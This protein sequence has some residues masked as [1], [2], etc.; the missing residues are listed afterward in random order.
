[1]AQIFPFRAY[2]YS[3]ERVDLS[4]VLTQP[5]DKITPAMQARYYGL[6]PHNLVRIERGRGEEGDTLTNNVYTRAAQTLEEWIA[7]GTLLRE[8]APAIY[9]YFQEYTVSG[10]RTRHV[11]KGF[12]ALGRIED[13]SAGVVYRH[14]L[15]HVGPKADRL[16]LLRHTRAHTGQLFMLCPDRERRLDALLDRQGKSAPAVNVTD[17]YGVAHKI[18]PV[19]DAAA[20][21]EFVQCMEN[22][23][24]VIA[25]GHHRYETALAYRNECR[26]K[27]PSAGPDAPHEKVMMTIFSTHGAGLAIL[28]TH[29]LLSGL[30]DFDFLK[31][32]RAVEPFFDWYAYPFAN[33]AER[34]S[35]M[36]EF[37]HDLAARGRGD[38]AGRR[39]IGIY[40]GGQPADG[41]A[42]YLFLLKCGAD[43]A[44]LLPD[45]APAQ[46]QLDVV[47]LHR[48]LLERGLAVTAE[49][50]ERG[51]HVAYEREMES[52]IAAVDRGETQMACLLNPVRVEQ[53]SE[54][55]LAGQVLPQK[56]TDFYPKLLS[57]I[58][59]YRLE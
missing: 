22:R 57:G 11:R 48:L 56:S 49:D 24:L 31:F 15:T 37:R 16:E 54:L 42:Y 29:R 9:V 32:R 55:A 39:T 33:D 26:E 2:R 34:T 59:I 35:A 50:V 7:D 41:R 44:D 40:P 52:S 28:P 46:H 38:T 53:V 6:D 1:M 13:Y 43:L 3:P 20:A 27:F 19:T 18:W 4:R 23:K 8:E 14:E 10:M 17:E 45:V 30:R 51:R 5:Y 47:L 21:G 12:I 25:D 58:T 36:E